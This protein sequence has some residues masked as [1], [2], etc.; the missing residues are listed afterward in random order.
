[1]ARSL[2]SLKRNTEAR[3]VDIE[4]VIFFNY[5][6]SQATY[7]V[8]RIYDA[9]C[10]EFGA[11]Y[12]FRDFDSLMGGT[13]W[14]EGINKALTGCKAIVAHIGDG[15]EAEIKSNIEGTDWV[16]Q[17]LETGLKAESKP[18]LI[19]VFTSEKRGDFNLSARL[20]TL[21]VELPDSPNIEHIKTAL[22]KQQGIFLGTD[23]DFRQ[24]LE[25]L[26]EALWSI[27]RADPR[28]RAPPNE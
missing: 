17:E 5:R 24:D 23:P 9:L 20:N 10:Q 14:E 26:L 11:G 12:V 28:R 6:R 4:P 7:A 1:M 18:I 25:R 15:W 16:R 22:A 8:G 3:A 21:K 19:P 13:V 27:I 2:V